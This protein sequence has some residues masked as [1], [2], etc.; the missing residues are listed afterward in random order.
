MK[1]HKILIMVLALLCGV[2]PVGATLDPGFESDFIS[3]KNIVQN[4]C[5][6]SRVYGT[7]EDLNQVKESNQAHM[8]CLLNDVLVRAEQG[9]G[10]VSDRK[11]EGSTIVEIQSVQRQR[12][13]QTQCDD[14]ANVSY[15]VCRV[16]EALLSEY[17]AYDMYL[18]AKA[19]QDII[20][21]RKNGNVQSAQLNMLTQ[22]E[23]ER[24][25]SR[26]ALRESIELYRH[27]ARAKA[28][29][30]TIQNENERMRDI[31]LEFADIS[32]GIATFPDKFI[33][34]PALQC[35]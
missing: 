5:N 14:T 35:K 2:L 13:L 12:G 7:S 19:E 17:C 21:E 22:I 31:A 24:E 6:A 11:C 27:Y 25:K 26:L 30:D 10:Y 1:S 16:T 33:P 9:E 3:G 32:R 8:N 29:S 18:W 15:G 20:G 28:L 23:A 34:A 4:L